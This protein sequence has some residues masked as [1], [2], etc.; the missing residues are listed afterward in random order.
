LELTLRRSG[1]GEPIQRAREIKMTAA[2]PVADIATLEA[3]L[4]EAEEL[5]QAIVTLAEA[6]EGPDIVRVVKAPPKRG[7]ATLRQFVARSVGDFVD[8][9]HG[10]ATTSQLPDLYPALCLT[11]GQLEEQ[12]ALLLLD[13][14]LALDQ[15]D[16]IAREEKKHKTDA[17]ERRK[18]VALAEIA[19]Q[20]Q[21]GLEA[22]S[23]RQK[24]ARE[25]QN[26]AAAAAG[27][28][29]M[30]FRD[31]Q[32][33]AGW[34]LGSLTAKLK[35]AEIA[36]PLVLEPTTALP[37]VIFSKTPL[38]RQQ[39]LATVN[40]LICHLLKQLPPG[41]LQLAIVDA[42]SLGQNVASFIHL[43]DFDANLL[44]EKIM[45]ERLDVERLISKLAEHAAMIIQKYL[46][47][48]F[49]DIAAFNRQA[50]EIAEPYRLLVILDAPAGV[51]EDAAERLATLLANGARSGVLTVMHCDAQRK[52]PRE[53]QEDLEGL[54]VVLDEADDGTFRLRDEVLGDCPVMLNEGLLLD[55]IQA[56]VEQV[57]KAARDAS[58]VEIAYQD[59]EAA[60]KIGSYWRASSAEELRVPLGPTGANR[61]RYLTLGK[62][63]SQHVLIAGKTGSGKSTLLHVIITGLAL[64][65]SPSEL[66]LYLIDF[67]K[68]VEFKQYVTYGMPHLRVVAIESEREFGLSVLRGLDATLQERGELFRDAGAEDVKSYRERSGQTLPRIVLIVDEF[69][70][71]FA[72][73]DAIAAKISQILDRLVRQGRAFGVHVLMGS[74]TLA[75]TYMLARSS[76]EQMAVRIAL[77][78]SEADSR[79][80]LSEENSAGRSL[81]RP[82]AAIYNDRNG[83]V[84][85]NDSFQVA[86][87]S[88]EEH[89]RYLHLLR[90]L[91]CDEFVPAPVVFEGS[92]PAAFA[93]AP[94]VARLRAGEVAP[95]T[96]LLGQPVSI[97]DACAV[98][99]RR[100]SG[101]HLLI[102][103]MNAESAESIFRSVIYSLVKNPV[104]RGRVIMVDLALRADE[105]E[106]F[107]ASAE[108]LGEDLEI[109]SPRQLVSLLAGWRERMEEPRQEEVYLAFFGLH[110]A[111]DIQPH[112]DFGGLSMSFSDEPAPATPG[113]QLGDLL[114][115]GPEHGI[116]V[117][118]WCD[119]APNL[120]RRVS[121]PT[122]REF[123]MR[124]L[125]QMSLQDSLALT[126]SPAASRLG[127]GRAVF[128]SDEL[129][130]QETFKPYAVAARVTDA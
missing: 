109:V 53:L 106:R 90:N 26:L 79:L 91:R 114:R 108:W 115:E 124:V 38:G 30:A 39:A 9:N 59:V 29:L 95:G 77:P 96:V 1:W 48:D 87:L 73:D 56:L 6:T 93:T 83:L 113:Q 64:R 118:A 76:L 130:R 36:L 2:A 63:T 12:L 43:A 8:A 68:G 10:K 44:H 103:G 60:A 15:Q 86:W 57:G 7:F 20:E 65:Y 69:Q 102:V 101:S 16:E 104:R 35:N 66:Q 121:A 75:G 71:F 33:N 42:L 19:S 61:L 46:R 4:T 55:Q 81:T 3:R 54:A 98:Q 92:A 74:Q 67:K 18:A 126:D 112:D 97:D 23:R 120:T 62:G 89:E 99:F 24:Q 85:G 127:L 50:G 52:M 17:L 72:E 14:E 47:S 107:G 45:T 13:A 34:Q 51:G 25:V 27:N 122:V 94:F 82:G 41:K 5:A 11:I 105:P 49:A 125:F 116:H 123:E 117:L 70:E 58:G 128:T 119:S 32:P 111:R 21:E 78:C 40:S 80:I 129:G 84:E 37:L 100:Q 88:K 22:L 110:R 31:T 28:T